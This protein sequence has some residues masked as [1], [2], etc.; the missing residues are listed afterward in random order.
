MSAE[1]EEEK[2][3]SPLVVHK[4]TD[5]SYVDTAVKVDVEYTHNEDGV[6]TLERHRFKRVKKKK[7]WP[8]F[9]MLAVVIVAVVCAFYLSRTKDPVENKTTAPTAEND[10]T[11]NFEDRFKNVIT[12]KGTYIFFEGEEVDGLNGLEKEI[13][14]LDKGTFL[15]VQDESADIMFLDDEILPLLDSYGIKY[16]TKYIISSGLKSQYEE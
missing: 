7:K 4:V 3:D 16:D 15:T 14:Y 6:A 2:L 8:Y 1:F 5:A 13:K 11:L 10:V 12:V 9:L